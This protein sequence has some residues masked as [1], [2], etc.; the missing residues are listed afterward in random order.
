MLFTS[1]IS[2]SRFLGQCLLVHFPKQTTVLNIK[3]TNH[4]QQQPVMHNPTPPH[5][6]IPISDMT[7]HQYFSSKHSSICWKQAPG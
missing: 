5:E 7:K 6:N 1:D 4:I 2:N 3:F